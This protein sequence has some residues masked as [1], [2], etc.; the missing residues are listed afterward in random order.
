MGG[1]AAATQ[2]DEFAKRT[3]LDPR[4][5]VRELLVASDGKS[6][7]AWRAGSSRRPD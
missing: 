2:L 5:D 6:A 1:G 4:K 3:G 7:V